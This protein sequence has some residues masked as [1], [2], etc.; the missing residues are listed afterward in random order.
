[1]GAAKKS[2]LVHRVIDEEDYLKLYTDIL[3]GVSSDY[4]NLYIMEDD[5][6][7]YLIDCNNVYA[8]M[9]GFYDLN[10]ERMEK[11]AIEAGLIYDAYRF[12]IKITPS[13]LEDGIKR[14]GVLVKALEKYR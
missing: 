4:L 11:A 10:E 9:D 7:V 5:D 3:L 14:F 6:G 12:Y 1:M 13:K 2:S 8:I